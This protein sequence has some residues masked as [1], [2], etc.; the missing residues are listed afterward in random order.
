MGNQVETKLLKTIGS[1]L[2][3]FPEYWEDE[4]LLRSKV[5]EDVRSYHESVISA[6]LSNDLIQETYS[7]KFG[8]TVIFKTEDFIDMLRYKSYWDNSYTKYTNEVGLTSEGK[9]L[10]YNTDVVLDFPHK[11]GVLEG[12][13]TEEE[14]GQEEIYYHNVLAK[15]EIDSLFSPKVLSNIKKYDQNGKHKVTEF[16]DSDNLIIKGNNLIALHTLKEKYAGKVKLIYI[17]PPYNTGSDSFKYNDRF[18]HSTWLTFMKNRLEIAKEL[19]APNGSIWINIDDDESHY[20]KVLADE[21]FGR[22]NFINNVI[23]QK[24]YAPQNDATWFTDNHDH[25]LVYAKSK[26]LWRPVLLPRSER[27]LRYYIHDDNDGRGLWRTDNILV[28]SFTKDRVFPVK[29]PNTGETFYPPEGRCWRYARDTFEKMIDEN[30][31]YWGKDGT[32]RPQV[33]RYLKNVKQGITPLTIWLREEV[34]D[35]QEA[36]KEINDFNFEFSFETPKPERLL[37]RIIHIGSEKNDIVL[38]FFMG[39]STTQA[40]AHKMNRQYIGVEQMDYIE[41]VSVPRLK[42]VIE[43]EQGGISEDVEWQGGGSFVYAELCSLNKHYLTKVQEADDEDSLD[44]VLQEMKVN[45]Y[46][47]F[48]V[49]FERLSP[50]D[51]AY[52][53]L[54]LDDKKDVLIQ[55]LD[56]NQLYLS[57]SEIDDTQYN[58]P[59]SVRKFNHSFYKQNGDQDE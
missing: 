3:N 5:I 57:Y 42:K 10:K 49:D 19:I 15:E 53:S 55:A 47:N 38:D 33:K 54:S 44:K 58:L 8:E 12:G 29:N 22:E 35:N 46:L 41:T 21:I 11:D 52:Q 56:M 28:K 43:G 50:N 39:S 40:V 45:A 59:E 16:K 48:K 30:R 1:V 20:L 9:Y 26:E 36:K 2:K 51:Q 17:D 13:M 4:T 18:N 14:V 6:L 24:K 37:E 34:A 27:Q 7:I 25:L 31:I 23:W 32:G